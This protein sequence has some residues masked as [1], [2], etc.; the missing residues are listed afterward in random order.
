MIRGMEEKNLIKNTTGYDEETTIDL[1]EIFYLLLENIWKIIICMIV[2][3]GLA[4]GGTKL[5]IE[6]TFLATSKIYVVSASNNSVINLSDL[7]VGSQLTSDYQ[8]LLVARP[9]LQDVIKNLNL[10]MDYKELEKTISITNTSGTRILNINV[11]TKN[12]QTS[13]DI[14]N[15]LAKQATVYLPEVM[16]T[17]SP[18]IVESAIAPSKKAA[19]SYAKN[20][21]LGVL[22]GAVLMCGYLIVKYVA[23]DTVVTAEDV[24]KYFGTMPLGSIPESRTSS[25]K[26]KKGGN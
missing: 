4:F 23:N 22:I 16:E 7:Q 9:V 12:A 5:L 10:D 26:R 6:P 8:E 25:K 18:N 21:L 11:T 19:P 13:A 14:A 15:E 17:E 20:T 2:C 24:E 1:V 3:G